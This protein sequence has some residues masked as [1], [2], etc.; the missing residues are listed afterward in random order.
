MLRLQVLLQGIEI[1]LYPFSNNPFLDSLL[2]ETNQRSLAVVE[3]YQLQL[4]TDDDVLERKIFQIAVDK[5]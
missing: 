4:V 1:G 2:L 5:G 3:L